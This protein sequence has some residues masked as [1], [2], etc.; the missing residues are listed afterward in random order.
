[1][2][3][4]FLIL[5][6]AAWL[7][8]AWNGYAQAVGEHDEAAAAEAVAP[9]LFAPVPLLTPT[10]LA[11]GALLLDEESARRALALGF[12]AV[13]AA[14][15]EQLVANS[16]AGSATR[17][18]AALLLTTARLELGDVPGAA[19]ALSN[20]GPTRP[21][22][23]RLR[24]G[25]IAAREGRVAEAQ[26]ALASLRVENL[27]E[28]ER[29]W[30][31]LLQ[32]MVA[33]AGRD[34][35]GAGLA[36]DQAFA[37]AVSDWQRARLRLTRERLRLAQG[38][39]TEEQAAE[40][41]QLAERYAGREVGTDY[42]VQHAVALALL[43][44]TEL[45]TGYLQEHLATLTDPVTA[46]QRDN[47][48]LMLGLVAGPGPGAGR[49]A[50][51]Q[52]LVGGAEAS[53]QRMAL[54]LLTEGAET[55]E[56]RARLRRLLDELLAR[57][58]AHDLTEELLLAR[59]E[60]ALRDQSYA[61]A[62][63]DAKSLLAR[64]PS[65]AQRGR[66]LTQLASI[67]W[68]LKRFRTAADFAAQAASAST[69]DGERAALRLLAAEASYRAEDY[70]AAA[71][72]YATVIDAPP[73]GVV[74]AE[75][76]FQAM[77]AEIAAKQLGKA[78]EVIDRLAFDPRFDATTRWQAEWNLARE[79]QVA[80]Q[81]ELALA[82]LSRLRAESGAEQ[83]PPA[84]RARLAWLQ[85]R[86]ARETGRVEQALELAQALPG[87]LAQ[88]EETLA[89][90]ITGLGR[91]V[92][93]EALFGLDRAEEALA[94][95]QKLRVDLP[96][97]EAALQSFIV[98][99]DIRAAAG[100]L[101]DAQRLLTQFSE[102][103]RD[104]EFA[105]Y[106]IYQAALNAERRGENVFF[107]EA[108]V[109]LE[110][111]IKTYP[112]NELIFD[113]RK[114]QGDLLRRLGDFAA[115]QRIYELLTNDFSQHRNRSAVLAAQMALADSHRAQAVRDPS[116][117]E[118][119]ITILERLRDL[120]DAPTDIRAEAGF[121]LGDV[122]ATR[123]PTEALAAW[124]A[125]A[126]ALVVDRTRA[127]ELGSQGRYWMGRLL[128][129]MA[130]LLEQQGRGDEARDTWRLIVERGLPGFAIA[131]TRIAAGTKASP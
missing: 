117:F 2:A 99:A 63:A 76:M 6:F 29:P 31:Y 18:S 125:V 50:L 92:A 52:L 127:S 81:G 74:P 30:L 60:L 1:M 78:A 61:A 130:G 3:P 114:K 109:L 38:E 35:A 128:V 4:R 126:N 70:A 68:E 107:R 112:T 106:A 120:A 46:K 40:L 116:H 111:L 9:T 118:S 8:P 119:A 7:L 25:L 75:V 14:Q 129:S 100:A 131:R 71:E 80:G 104:H 36:Y 91:L 37:A 44:K 51:E 113:A 27:P 95:L 101:V 108:Y 85:A 123:A 11:P 97:S 49:A 65:S 32:G 13:A 47:V 102:D 110:G 83:Q 55:P 56:A 122:L 15:A 62:E 103:Y 16:A 121:K 39:A 115:A 57:T 33:E 73:P 28:A 86:L 19:R 69:E 21:P 58:P 22:R 93:A 42:A 59:A 48:S 88:V 41:L 45:A 10:P 96:G 53:R 43:G 26:A 72:M 89:R 77:M 94:E 5:T 12:A 124:G 82:R 87:Q 66:A 105:P 90:E 24:A 20:H 98:E 64:F 23:Q 17:D 79:L 54:S 67:A 34:P 84:L